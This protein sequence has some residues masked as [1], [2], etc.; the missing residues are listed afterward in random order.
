MCVF[1][2]ELAANNV[3]TNIF[4]VII[5]DSARDSALLRRMVRKKIAD[6][7]SFIYKCLQAS[8]THSIMGA[9]TS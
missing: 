3:D 9:P 8:G 6:Y 2:K 7:Y 4:Q 5:D 1:F